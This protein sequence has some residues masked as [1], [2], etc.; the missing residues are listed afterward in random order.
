MW[1]KQT[2]HIKFQGLFSKKNIFFRM[3]SATNFAWCF[4]LTMFEQLGPDIFLKSMRWYTV[5]TPSYL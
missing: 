1:I 3:S 2:I 4:K 5:D